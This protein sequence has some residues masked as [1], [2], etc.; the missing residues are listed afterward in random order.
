MHINDFPTKAIELKPLGS[1]PAAAHYFDPDH[2][3]AVVAAW[4][5]G[6]PLLVKGEP[7]TGKSQ[8]ANAVA[9]VLK[10]QFISIGI[11][12]R[13]EYQDL[14]WE[15]DAV[16]R[17][18]EAQ[19]IGA[20]GQVSDNERNAKLAKEKFIIPGPLWWAVRPKSAEIQSSKIEQKTHP[21]LG[22]KNA[23]NG[24]VLLIDEIDKADANLPNG[25][26]EVLGNGNFI[27]PVEMESETP[28][29]PLV[30]ITSNDERQ[31]PPAFERRCLVL[32]IKLP[33]P[34]EALVKYLTELANAHKQHVEPLK[35][36]P[37]ETIQWAAELLSEIRSDTPAD[38]RAPGVAE[39]LDLLR[40]VSGMKWSKQQA[41]R[42]Q[43]LLRQIVLSKQD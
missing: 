22:E 33:E 26:L 7:G 1:W 12:P 36:L 8:L 3:K 17:L 43:A 32:T 5:A 14:L 41:Q 16:A 6:R 38:V 39:F 9:R 18:A 28:R 30:I 31:L 37:D 21:V 27:P 34:G 42:E 23:N 10:W 19:L 4:H 2:I 24:L 25:L 15:F 35:K 13:T 40:V 11:Q 20:Q 29:K